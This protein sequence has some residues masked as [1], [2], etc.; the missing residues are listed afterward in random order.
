MSTMAQSSARLPNATT[1]TIAPFTMSPSPGS[2]ACAPL[3]DTTSPLR[4]CDSPLRS[5]ARRE[6]SSCWGGES[7]PGVSRL[8]AMPADGMIAVRTAAMSSAHPAPD[9]SG[10]IKLSRPA[11]KSGSS[12]HLAAGH[13]C[14]GHD[15]F[16]KPA[17]TPDQVRAGF[18]GIM[19]LAQPDQH[20]ARHDR[21]RGNDAGRAKRLAQ[22]DDRNQGAEQDTGFPKRRHDGD[23]RNR[24]ARVA[25]GGEQHGGEDE[26]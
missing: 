24:P 19:R 9:S 22:D 6:V 3:C 12:G 18:F 16:R 2:G 7:W 14:F 5:T 21:E 26:R 11:K 23:R 20:Q 15:L 8:G 17:S 13:P 25:G 10:K 4:D 1:R